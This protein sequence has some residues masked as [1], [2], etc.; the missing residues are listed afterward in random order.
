VLKN[1][2]NHLLGDY[3]SLGFSLSAVDDHIIELCFHGRR[4]AVFNSLGITGQGVAEAY[5]AH[6]GEL[7]QPE[8]P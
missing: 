7:K 1:H 6:T 3:Q 4:V 5:Q 2:L 8:K